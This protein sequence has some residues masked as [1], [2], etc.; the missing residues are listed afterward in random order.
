MKRRCSLSRER[1]NFSK[2][3]SSAAGNVASICFVV[4]CQEN[5]VSSQAHRRRIDILLGEFGAFLDPFLRVV[6]LG[7]GVIDRDT[8]KPVSVVGVEHGAIG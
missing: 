1:R 3:T 2:P 8:A 7:G 4:A 6:N 5:G